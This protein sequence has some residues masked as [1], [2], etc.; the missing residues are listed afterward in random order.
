M[1][2]PL[3]S[4][5]DRRDPTGGL[6]VIIF[7][8]VVLPALVLVWS[9]RSVIAGKPLGSP[10]NEHKIY[11]GAVKNGE[12]WFSANRLSGRM[13]DL[14]SYDCRIKR[15]D[16]T[17]GVEHETGIG[18]KNEDFYPF[19]LGDDMYA[20]NWSKG[21]IYRIAGT[22]LEKFADLPAHS[23]QFFAY[24]FLYEGQITTIVEAAGDGFRLV[25]WN[26]G[27]WIDGRRIRLPGCGASWKDPTDQES[28]SVILKPSDQLGPT[29]RAYIHVVHDGHEYHVFQTSFQGFAAYRRGLEF[30]DDTN[31]EVSA[32]APAN[33]LHQPMGW[34]KVAP[35]RPECW[36][37]WFACDRDGPVFS[38]SDP[39][40][41][42]R[43]D[44]K[45]EDITGRGS[46][47]GRMVLLVD[48][49]EDHA[50]LID[51]DQ[52]WSTAKIYR[53]QGNTILPAHLSLPG[54]VPE[55]LDR[56][57]R[58]IYGVVSAWLLHHLIVLGGAALL[59]RLHSNPVIRF[60]L[61]R[62]ELASIG[63]RSLAAACD[64]LFGVMVY[65][66][67]VYSELQNRFGLKDFEAARQRC[68]NLLSFEQAIASLLQ[69]QPLTTVINRYVWE[70][71]RLTFQTQHEFITYTVGAFVVLEFLK[72][73]FENRLGVTPG[74][75]LLGLRTVRST[76][77]PARF[78]QRIVREL[79]FPIDLPLLIT[80]VP[81]VISMVYSPSRQRIG[82]RIAD[83]VVI[84]AGSIVSER[85]LA[86]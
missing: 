84:R 51:E 68:V 79:L 49:A 42:R 33:A 63:R 40:P 48:R 73:C 52:R 46:L 13:F 45:W 39:I 38:G 6:V 41:V 17:T 37:Y 66:A 29:D 47:R 81:A 85:G 61:E 69:A 3:T 25:H 76:L 8:G 35:A 30:A 26:E 44:G 14:N 20:M 75:W 70:P 7:L 10:A 50:F 67:I 71:L 72:V 34:L 15:L 65:C 1:S 59:S 11:Q 12:L 32:L 19:P 22:S 60:G 86:G 82:D 80:S 64:G 74:K 78:W 24:P 27:K 2:S 36:W 55:Y 9:I 58:L 16:L 56:W 57:K 4:S 53:F 28:N 54:S 23:A 31:E 62:A 18:L 43:K 77:R 21:V 5:V 83:T